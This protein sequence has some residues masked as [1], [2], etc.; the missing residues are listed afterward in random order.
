[1]ADYFLTGVNEFLGHASGWFGLSDEE[2]DDAAYVIERLTL[3]R[4]RAN[5]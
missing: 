4:R 5:I 3:G 1:V 2:C